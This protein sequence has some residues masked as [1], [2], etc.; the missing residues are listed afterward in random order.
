MIIKPRIRGFICTNAHPVGCRAHV[1]EQIAYTQDLGYRN[2][3]KNALVIGCSA[4]YG[5]A[6]RIVATFGFGANSLGISF[7]REPTAT[8]TASAGWYNNLAFDRAA[9]SDGFQSL[10][11]NADAFAD[12]TKNDAIALIKE[13]MG[14][15][16]LLVYSLAA[17][18]RCHPRT[19]VTHR[20][21]IM[22]IGSSHS[23]KTLALDF[24]NRAAVLK[25]VRVEPA[26]EDEISDTVAVMG[27]EDWQMWVDL[28]A[29]ERLIMDG[30]KTIAFTYL[31]NELTY[32][33]YRG[34]TLGRAK[35]D[36]DRARRELNA[37]LDSRNGVAQLA[38]LKAVVTQASTAIPVVP[39]YFSILFD[40]MKQAANHEGTIEH[41]NRL[42]REQLYSGSALRTDDEGRIRMDNFEELPEI[43]NEVVRRWQLVTQE[44]IH[45]LADVKGFMNDF[46]KLFGFE[47]HG[48]DY[49]LDVDPF[50]E[51]IHP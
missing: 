8:R 18:L 40:V 41:I 28:L 45:E 15:I 43:Q 49:A 46:M 20:S 26:T 30:F 10:T 25:D 22:P 16:D 14:G 39:L 36:L 51:E 35:E 19:G 27:G 32:P 7:E 17:P 21:A 29:A 48:V 50:G 12:E 31:G 37:V 4:G 23:S 24:S 6:S 38:V 13:R 2:S 34:G 42:F 9:Q 33:I 47:V 3:I 1:Q 5:L 44:N 11:I